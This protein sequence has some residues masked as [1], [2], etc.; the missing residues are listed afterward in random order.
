MENTV[1]LYTERKN[2]DIG[3]KRESWWS[4]VFLSTCLLLLSAG[5]VQW[6][7]VFCRGK[8]TPKIDPWSRG[9]VLTSARFCV[10]RD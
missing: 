2:N 5:T 3:A 4:N 7:W 8:K 6:M 1:C 10:A 9:R